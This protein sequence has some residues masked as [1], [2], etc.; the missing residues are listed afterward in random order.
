MRPGLPQAASCADYAGS[1]SALVHA[2]K[3]SGSAILGGQL[4]APMAAQ[5][6][7]CAVGCDARQKGG[8][9]QPLIL[10]PAPSRKSITKRRGFVPSVVLAKQVA[11][12]LNARGRRARVWNGLRLIDE[13][14]DQSQLG[15]TA[16][17]LNVAGKM[18]LTGAP[19]AGIL[20]LLDDI[21]TTGATLAEA[22]R[23][24]SEAGLT[25]GLAVTFAETL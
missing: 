25:V 22:N 20:V 7:E 14:L 17:A 16:R 19:G 4:A 6:I 2:F 10:V 5:V 21:V 11:R 9:P 8:E 24:L 23:A 13:V 3:E 18:R 1:V 15:K 12:R